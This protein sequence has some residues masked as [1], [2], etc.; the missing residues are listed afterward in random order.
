[1]ETNAQELAGDWRSYANRKLSPP[2]SPHA[3]KSPTQELGE[4]LFRLGIHKGFTS[5]SAKVPDYKI[6][7]IFVG[8]LTDAKSIEYPYRDLFGVLQTVVIS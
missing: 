3:D 5:F 7:G 1:V 4:E 6:L 8:R 2:S